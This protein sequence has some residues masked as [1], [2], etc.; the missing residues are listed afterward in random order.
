MRLVVN[1]ANGKVRLVGLQ[2]KKSRCTKVERAPSSGSTCT[3]T[4]PAIAASF[5]LHLHHLAFGRIWLDTR[6]DHFTA[7][8]DCIHAPT[9]YSSELGYPTSLHESACVALLKARE[10][11]CLAPSIRPFYHSTLARHNGYQQLESGRS[12]PNPVGSLYHAK[13]CGGKEQGRSSRLPRE[14]SK[15]IRSM[16]H[17]SYY[18]P[19]LFYLARSTSF[20][21]NYVEGKGP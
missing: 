6:K 8:I 15:V 5:G 3:C 16:E 2:V 21:S 12:C 1:R 13:S 7:S 11:V 9:Y 10:P 19:R 18:A 14:V 20:R 4:A 17:D